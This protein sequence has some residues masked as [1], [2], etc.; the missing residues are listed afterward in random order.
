MMYVHLKLLW[1]SRVLFV[2]VLDLFWI[3]TWFLMTLPKFGLLFVAHIISEVWSLDFC[4]PCLV[5]KIN[6]DLTSFHAKLQLVQ[7]FSFCALAF[8]HDA[9][10][11]SSYYRPSVYWPCFGGLFLVSHSNFLDL[12]YSKTLWQLQ[13]LRPLDLPPGYIFNKF[14]FIRSL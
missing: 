14:W 11:N 2:F 8:G 13:C 10:N 4:P 6:L 9:L 3:H 12:V 7:P 5:W 1:G